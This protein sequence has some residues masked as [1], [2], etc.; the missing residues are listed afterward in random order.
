MIDLAT[1][2]R[3]DGDLLVTESGDIEVTESLRQ[4]ILIRLRWISGEWRLGPGMGFPYYEHVFVKN[5]DLQLI[6]RLIRDEVMK[7]DGV[8]SV[9]V[10]KA[11]YNEQERTLRIRFTVATDLERFDEEVTLNG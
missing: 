10:T 3:G 4:A 6:R 1:D 7:V 9:S 2:V 5:P 8:R 11:T